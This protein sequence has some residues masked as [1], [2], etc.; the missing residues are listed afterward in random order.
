M[1]YADFLTGR[2]GAATATCCPFFQARP[3]GLYGVGIDAVP[4]QDAW[5]LGLPGFAGH[6][7]RPGARARA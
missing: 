1:S 2:A 5:G 4:A 7:A 3:H 6:G